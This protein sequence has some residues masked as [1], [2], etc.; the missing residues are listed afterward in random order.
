MFYSVVSKQ[1]QM[2]DDML[3]DNESFTTISSS[4]FLDDSVPHMSIQIP[5][6]LARK[7]SQQE[8]VTVVSHLYYNVEEL[9]PG[10]LPG[11][12]NK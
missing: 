2:L 3:E 9:F 7:F 8:I 10:G 12:E 1:L 4:E 5:L 6:E 11:K